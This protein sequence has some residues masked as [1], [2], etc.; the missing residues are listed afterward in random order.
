MADTS[1]EWADKVWNPIAGCSIVSPG[2]TN[3][4]AMKMA[5]RIEAMGHAKYAGLTQ[6]SKA[7]AVWT[8]KISIDEKA[9]LAP[10]R[11]KKP[12]RVFV[13]SMSDLFHPDVPDEIIDIVF[14]VMASAHRQTFQVL[15]KRPG[16][17]REYLLALVAEG[18]E[19]CRHYIDVTM[20]VSRAARQALNPPMSEPPPPTPALRALYDRAVGAMRARGLCADSNS[21][22][23]VS[24]PERHWRPWPLPN[25]WLGVSVE[26]QEEADARIPGL[27]A[28]P[29]AIRFVSAEPL[30]EDLGAV[31]LTGIDW[32][33][34][35]GESG[36]R[37]RDC[38]IEAITNLMRQADAAGTAVFVKQLGARVFL[39]GVR[40]KL[41]D[42]KGADMAEWPADLR[43]RNLPDTASMRGQ[44]A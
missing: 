5:A 21:C 2:C 3:C 32:L 11:W 8:G 14:A 1:I 26:R 24:L 13:N 9:L 6:P 33:I 10:L 23:G 37:A 7:G 12:A 35:G 42:R 40:L 43:I 34:L 4:Y 15:T 22:A 38:S 19:R 31:D 39:D 29:A 36:G 20:A 16:R 17:M 41:A 25:V 44:H 30:L 27:L 28:T 18:P